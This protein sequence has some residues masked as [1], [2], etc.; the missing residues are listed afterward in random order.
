MTSGLNRSG[1]V[2]GVV[3]SV[4]CLIAT[5]TTV[6]SSVRR[7]ALRSTDLGGIRRQAL[8]L[9]PRGSRLQDAASRLVD[10]G[11]LCTPMPHLMPDVSSASLLC[12]SNGRG[13]PD[14]PAINVTVLTR[15]GLISEIEVWN[16]MARADSDEG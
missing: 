5:V 4:A 16:V 9:F 7:Q 14:F 13:Y 10:M 12:A 6:D 11:F 15:N 8:G 3:M 2:L 1:L